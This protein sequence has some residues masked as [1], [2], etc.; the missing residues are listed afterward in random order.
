MWRF[1][2]FVSGDEPVAHVSALKGWA[3]EFLFGLA[4]V[5]VA[6]CIWAIFYLHN[7]KEKDE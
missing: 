2:K 6:L 3:G 7:R 4:A 1:Y 5:G